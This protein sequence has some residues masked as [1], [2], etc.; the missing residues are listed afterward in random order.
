MLNYQKITEEYIINKE[1]KLKIDQAYINSL[2]K[3]DSNS[4]YFNK[5]IIFELDSTTYY[6]FNKKWNIDTSSLKDK[7]KEITDTIEIIKYR[8]DTTNQF[9]I[10]SFNNIFCDT[11]NIDS[12]V[13][14]EKQKIE[15][16]YASNK[17]LKLNKLEEDYIRSISFDG[18]NDKGIYNLLFKNY[19]YQECL[20]KQINL[21]LDLKGGIS[22][23][24]EVDI[25]DVLVN[26]AEKRSGHYDNFISKL[27]AADKE[28]ENSSVDYL[29]LVKR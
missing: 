6:E 2:T 23:T 24:L 11:T 26:W 29:D 21:G 7:L 18:N 25:R 22:V 15:D 13:L 1:R 28:M 19:T 27:N 12:L 10:F 16:D 3:K 14:A 8:L 4:N 9:G 20:D 5:E 17:T